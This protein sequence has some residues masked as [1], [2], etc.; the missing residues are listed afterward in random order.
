MR[1]AAPAARHT[2]LGR[3]GVSLRD[4]SFMTGIS[5]DSEFALE[6]DPNGFPCAL[7]GE[8]SCLSGCHFFYL[9]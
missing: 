3:A 6:H 1:F 8:K 4:N 7:E 9:L 2:E 5:V